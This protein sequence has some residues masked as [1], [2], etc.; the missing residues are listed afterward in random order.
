MPLYN[1]L[2]YATPLGNAAMQAN[3]LMRA[4]K[5][6]KVHQNVLVFFKGNPKNIP[7]KFPQ[8]TYTNKEVEEFLKENK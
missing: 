4:R 5:I 2:V 8:I 1:E 7:N 3:C 6:V